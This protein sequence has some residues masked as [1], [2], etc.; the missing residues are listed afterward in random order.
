MMEEIPCIHDYLDPN[1]TVVVRPS[2]REAWCISCMRGRKLSTLND[3]SAQA[4]IAA[5]S[6]MLFGGG[7]RGNN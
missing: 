7:T 6:G 2:T 3:A 5:K 4:A 1:T